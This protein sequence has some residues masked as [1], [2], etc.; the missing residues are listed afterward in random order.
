L[1]IAQVG[2]HIQCETVR[3][4]PAA[5]MHP[6]RGDLSV[7]HPNPR[8]LRNTA[9][10][11]PKLRQHIYQHLFDRPR[12]RAHVALPFAQIHYG[13]A[14]H[15]SR[16]VI[17]DIPPPVRPAEGNTRPCQ[18]FFPRQHVLHMPVAPHGDGVGMLQ[19]QQLIANRSGLPLRHQLLLQF[20]RA[21]VFHPAQF[22]Q[23]ALR[24]ARH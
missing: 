1:K 7:A 4:H 22:L 10:L 19:Q 2:V 16:P 9:R 23:L 17:R 8:Q 3:C 12:I 11:D 24:P 6:N 21:A 13:I 15:L 5:D 18:Y 14:H 20:E